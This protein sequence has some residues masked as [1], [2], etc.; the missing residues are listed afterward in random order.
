MYCL[1]SLV[2]LL[3]GAVSA[4]I[5]TSTPLIV[6]AMN[7]IF[8][9]NFNWWV[10]GDVYNNIAW[11]A[12]AGNTANPYN[13]TYLHKFLKSIGSANVRY[14]GGTTS[15]YWNVSSSTFVDVNSPVCKTIS[16]DSRYTIKCSNYAAANTSNINVI[17]TDKLSIQAYGEQMAA[18]GIPWMYVTNLYTISVEEVIDSIHKLCDNNNP[19][20]PTYLELGNEYYLTN[21]FFNGSTIM[22]NSNV[23]MDLCEQ[24]YAATAHYFGD[25]VAGLSSYAGFTGTQP[26]NV[27]VQWN[28]GLFNHSGIAYDHLTVHIY[29]L[30][31]TNFRTAANSDP[32]NWYTLMLG[33]P[34]SSI[35]VVRDRFVT[36]FT[37]DVKL[38]LTE[39]N[40]NAAIV[41]S[42]KSGTPADAFAIGQM[43]QPAHGLFVASFYLSM[44]Q[45]PTV[46]TKAHIFQ[47]VRDNYLSAFLID[48]TGAY[49]YTPGQIFHNLA[50]IM[51][52]SASFGPVEFAGVPA[53][54]KLSWYNTYD[55]TL[56]ALQG[57][58]FYG[59]SNSSITYVVMN[60]V[61]N[62]I[63]ATLS[64]S[65][66]YKSVTIHEY[67]AN[68]S[69]STTT[70]PVD[71]DNLEGIYPLAGPAPIAISTVNKKGVYTHTFAPLALTVLTFNWFEVE[72]PTA[73]PTP[74]PVD[75]CGESVW[76]EQT[77]QSMSPYNAQWLVRIHTGENALYNAKIRVSPVPANI[78]NLNPVA[79][80]PGV[81]TIPEY[82]Y[83]NGAIPAYRSC[84]TF[85]YNTNGGLTPVNVTLANDACTQDTEGCSAT[86]TNTLASEW[87]SNG[88]LFQQYSVNVVNS[89]SRTIAG[90]NVQLEL[91][92][93]ASLYQYWNIA[94]VSGTTST[95]AVASG[96]IY[97]GSSNSNGG[98]QIT[99][100]NGV[101]G[102][103]YVSLA[104][105]S[106]V[107]Y[108]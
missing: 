17:G 68:T 44:M 19:A 55:K 47:S 54:P 40:Y 74:S 50:Y 90:I 9:M 27:Q 65:G 5:T 10:R 2:V 100:P 15:T 13:N 84:I 101:A 8:G 59:K 63:S 46:F 85:G 25:R 16:G 64:E 61:T 93:G 29:T 1:V 104:E 62:A 22:P 45:F 24:V 80:E 106:P 3:A 73:A 34:E 60:R 70:Y 67:I 6:P 99:V 12:S 86:V 35:R 105:S 82:L 102:T 30:S 14:P 57:V 20:C 41:G 79:G 21:F 43:F 83:E 71:L 108:A 31:T 97:A 89:A 42:D 7:D 36:Q 23:Y 87:V 107:C 72:E 94:P 58:L 96:N 91:T 33:W 32:A 88:V 48:S 38:W 76:F 11:P 69:I 28:S 39:F 95:Y 4:Q 37:P 18:A 98:Y 77:Q 66:P 52:S 53:I 51:K 81:Y 26:S 92:G 49:A 78:W 103:R 56:N 75:V